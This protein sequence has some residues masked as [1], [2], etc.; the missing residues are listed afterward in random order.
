MER[1]EEC[2][3][4]ILEAKNYILKMKKKL[5]DSNTSLKT[6]WAMLNHLLYDKK[7]PT[8]PPLLVDV[9]WFQTCK[10]ANI[11]DNFFTYICTPTDNASCLPSFLYRTGSR[12]KSFHVTENDILAIIKTL[13]PNKAQGCNNIT[14]EWIKICSQSLI[15]PLKTIFEHS[16]KK[17]N[18]QKLEKDECSSCP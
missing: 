15:L 4:Q 2:S 16:L 6:Y 17:V 3:K 1:S 8:I 7:L 12:I 11:F 5:A 18:F 14:V 13:D 9:G 10:K